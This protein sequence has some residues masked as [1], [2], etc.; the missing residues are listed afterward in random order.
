MN[1]D[2][3]DPLRMLDSEAEV[4]SL[5]AALREAQRNLPTAM[6]RESVALRLGLKPPAATPITRL[7]KLVGGSLGLLIVGGVA[8][9]LVVG[10][11]G[12][13]GVAA[14]HATPPSSILRQVAP[15]EASSASS[16]TT[17]EPSISPR[18]LVPVP[19]ETAL[20]NA[21]RAKLGTDPKGALALT[22]RHRKLYPQG[23][24]VQEREVIAV[25]ALRRQ[26]ERNEAQKRQEAFDK[27][28]PSS[29]HGRRIEVENAP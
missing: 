19:S 6:Q 27:S 18:S 3:R 11:G 20:L 24:F 4:M 22:E 13:A 26:G 2:G 25:E 12:T 15:P 5:R 1:R 8:S 28:Y 29:I 10:G 14:R 16:T 21:A 17:A 23:I 9:W 7:V